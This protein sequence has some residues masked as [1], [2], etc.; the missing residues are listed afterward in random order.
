MVGARRLGSGSIHVRRRRLYCERGYSL[1]PR[2]PIDDDRRNPGR[3]RPLSDRLCRA[4]H[5]RWTPRRHP[6]VETAVSARSDWVHY[7]FAVL[8]IGAFGRRVGHGASDAGRGR[9]A[10]DPAGA[11][12]D[13]RAVFRRGAGP[14]LRDIRLHAWFWRCRRLRPRG[15]SRRARPRRSRLA[16][17]FLCQRADRVRADDRGLV[18]DAIAARQARNPNS[19]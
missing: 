12:D 17:D 9:G 11:R 5:H 1:N 19:T 14:R 3:H 10:D 4:D 6:R 8:R 18:I 2:R 13:P 7:G 15:L 16:D